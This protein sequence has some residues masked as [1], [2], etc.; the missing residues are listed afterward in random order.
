MN[1]PGIVEKEIESVVDAPVDETTY[2]DAREYANELTDLLDRISK[3][4]QNKEL[5]F[6]TQAGIYEN[7]DRV[8]VVVNTQDEASLTKLK[9]FDK[10]GKLLEITYS[11]TTASF[12]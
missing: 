4:M 9:E 11:G 2:T 10:T 12:E 1:H 3:A 6:V 5:P 8:K 7:P